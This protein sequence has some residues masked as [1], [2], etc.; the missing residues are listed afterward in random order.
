[1]DPE[2]YQIILLA[3]G[4]F[5]AMLGFMFFVFR[6]FLNK[7]AEKEREAKENLLKAQENERS[8]IAQE[9]HDNLAP[10]LSI[11]QMHVS[12]VLEENNP[13]R[14]LL[15]LPEVQKQLHHAITIARDV[16]HVLSPNL[17][18]E[19]PLSTIIEDHIDKINQT[20]KIAIMFVHNIAGLA[21]APTKALI[22]SRVVQELL[23]NTLKHAKA[24][25][26]RIT[27]HRVDN[28]MQ[29]MYA[30]NGVGIKSDTI[31]SGLG[32]RNIESR[33]EILNGRTL[34]TNNQLGAGVKVEIYIPV[35][36]LAV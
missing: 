8:S 20:G 14:V 16:S 10:L 2:F 21:I 3:A 17:F 33:V 36:N 30:D 13:E 27:M 34:W 18:P 11:A 6:F 7:M 15:L 25:A 24:K 5:T 32:I 28:E 12:G 4:V 23:N 29:L 1:M 26:V 22:I 19:T 9:I 35:N 31:K